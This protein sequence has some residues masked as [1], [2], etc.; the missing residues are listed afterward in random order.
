[1]G[2]SFRI[3]VYIWPIIL[4]LSSHLTV[5][6]PSPRSLL[7][8][9]PQQRPVG[10]CPHLWGVAP[11]FCDPQEAFLCMCIHR[12]FPWCQ[13]YAPYLFT[14]AE[15]SFCH[16]L[17]PWSVWVKTKFEFYSI[18]QIPGVQPSV[19][20]ISYLMFTFV[21]SSYDGEFKKSND[22]VTLTHCWIPISCAQ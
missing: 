20:S 16:L 19:P 5:L 6:P 9:M 22:R 14:L 11:F 21:S 15:L 4:F 1:M 17:C 13:K 7:R 3:F 10:V 8:W 18:W 2:Q 12:C